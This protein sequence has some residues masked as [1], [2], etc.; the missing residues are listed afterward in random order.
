MFLFFCICGMGLEVLEKSSE[1]SGFIIL[2][3]ENAPTSN[4]QLHRLQNLQIPMTSMMMGMATPKIKETAMMKTQR[5][6]LPALKY[7]MTEKI[8][9]VMQRL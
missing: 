4:P 5:L 2:E 8:T 1:D 9:I 6:V 3:P 7:P